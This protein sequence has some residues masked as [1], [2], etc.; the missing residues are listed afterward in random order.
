MKQVKDL[1][2]AYGVTF[3]QPLNFTPFLYMLY[4]YIYVWLAA[5]QVMFSKKQILRHFAKSVIGQISTQ[6]VVPT[7]LFI[8]TG[9]P[10]VLP[11]VDADPCILSLEF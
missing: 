1:S 8:G 11:D 9:T 7:L 3:H 2:T 4:I 5:K 10:V 6:G